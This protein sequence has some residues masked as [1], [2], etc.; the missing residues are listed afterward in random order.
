MRHARTHHARTMNWRAHGARARGAFRRAGKTERTFDRNAVQHFE[1]AAERRDQ[2][3]APPL[4]RGETRHTRTH[5]A[6]AMER[7]AH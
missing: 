5:H 1:N 4:Q 6:R 7:R 2:T 3:R